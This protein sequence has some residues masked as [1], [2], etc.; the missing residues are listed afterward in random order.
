[1][2]RSVI[3]A[4]GITS[5][6]GVAVGPPQF[7]ENFPLRD[8]IPLRI[9]LADGTSQDIQSP[10]INT[11]A[12]AM[13]I[14]Q[15]VENIEWASE[16]GDPV[17]YAPHLRKNPLAAVPAKSVVYQIAKGDKTVPNPVATA[18][19]RAGDLADRAM[20][21]RHDLAFAPAVTGRSELH[22]VRR[23]GVG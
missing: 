12:G 13:A 1:V 5:L 10:V 19:L 18:L 16:S 15:V 6:G 3:N 9:G 17:A 21:Y 8:G 4:P 7:N 14:Q 11:V 23:I 22:P 20:F 2:R